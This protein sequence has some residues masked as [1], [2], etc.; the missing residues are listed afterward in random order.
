MQCHLREAFPGHTVEN[1]GVALPSPMFLSYFIC[2]HGT[3]RLLTCYI[4]YL[5]ISFITCNPQPYGACALLCPRS[6]TQCL[7]HSKSSK[8]GSV[9]AA[10]V[11]V[12]LILSVTPGAHRQ[13]RPCGPG[14]CLSGF[15]PPSAHN[16]K[17]EK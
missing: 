9:V 10:A 16:P 17:K 12:T 13:P 3:C 7:A 6:L 4:S 1:L 8:A 15:P 2:F 14:L 11:G 5:F